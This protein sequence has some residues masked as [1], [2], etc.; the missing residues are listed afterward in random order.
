[1]IDIATLL[2]IIELTIVIQENS[3]RNK[4]NNDIL[5]YLIWHLCIL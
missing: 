5:F 2:N 1:M 4:L 3:F